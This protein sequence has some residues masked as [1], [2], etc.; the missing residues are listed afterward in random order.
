M[1]IEVTFKDPDGVSNSVNEYVKLWADQFE[2]Q[3]TSEEIE[4]LKELR[5][6]SVNETL[7][8]LFMYGEYVT[9]EVDLITKKA[10]VV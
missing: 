1:K 5:T 8:E 9:I 10:R 2:G 6:E 7:S 4:S 3:L